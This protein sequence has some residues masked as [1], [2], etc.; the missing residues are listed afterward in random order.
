VIVIARRQAKDRLRGR[1][2]QVVDDACLAG[3][4]SSG[5]EPEVMALD[6]AELADVTSAIR[7]LAPAHREILGLNFGSGLSL[8]EVASVQEIS[9]GTVKSRITAARTALSRVL[10][11]KGQNR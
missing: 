8:P 1:Q 3:Q 2:L 7:Q 6:R 11:E 5:P 4:P 9:V 10:N